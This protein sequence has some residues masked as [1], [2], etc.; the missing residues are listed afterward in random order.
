MKSWVLWVGTSLYKQDMNDVKLVRNYLIITTFL[1]LLVIL[2]WKMVSHG[3][4]RVEVEHDLRES[5]DG[6]ADQ[7]VRCRISH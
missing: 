7:V 1:R 4:M 2:V 5:Y 6:C 3:P